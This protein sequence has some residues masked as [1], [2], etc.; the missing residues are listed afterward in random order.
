VACFQS[1][2]EGLNSEL[3]ANDSPVELSLAAIRLV[4]TASEHDIEWLKDQH[5]QRIRVVLA[6]PC[7]GLQAAGSKNAGSTTCSYCDHQVDAKDAATFSAILATLPTLDQCKL[8]HGSYN[9]RPALSEAMPS[10]IKWNFLG[11]RVCVRRLAAILGMCPRTFY[12]RDSVATSSHFLGAKPVMFMP[13]CC[14]FLLVG[15]CAWRS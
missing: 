14:V 8:L 6:N 12:K 11:A 7:S 15:R 10:R 5:L 2:G 3:P 1:T 9:N 13:H 4:A